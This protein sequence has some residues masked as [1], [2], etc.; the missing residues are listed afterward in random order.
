MSV[1]VYVPVVDEVYGGQQRG[2]KQLPALNNEI[3]ADFSKYF[4][5]FLSSYNS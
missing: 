1:N 3:L 2:V 5:D 4:A